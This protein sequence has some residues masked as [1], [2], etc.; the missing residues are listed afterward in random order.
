MPS[1]SDIKTKTVF[2]YN[3]INVGYYMR[4]RVG[5]NRDGCQK[6]GLDA[7]PEI[8][9]DNTLMFESRFESGN[10]MKA[11]KV[12]DTEYELYM[13]YDLYTSRHTQ[14]F[15]FQV[16]NAKPGRQYRFTLCNF[17]KSDSLYNSGIRDG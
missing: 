1:S 3:P 13:R 6:L 11:V 5:G 2:Y 10:L 15:Y 17:L 7:V 4:S 12:S 14:W 8:D 9:I 16:K